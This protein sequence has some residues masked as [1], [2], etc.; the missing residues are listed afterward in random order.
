MLVEFTRRGISVKDL[1][2]WKI[3][4][5]PDLY[6]MVYNADEEVILSSREEA[7]ENN[8]AQLITIGI[9]ERFGVAASIAKNLI[10]GRIKL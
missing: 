1:S 9:P 7:E 3:G 10:K 5:L 6:I 2:L 8:L 4:S